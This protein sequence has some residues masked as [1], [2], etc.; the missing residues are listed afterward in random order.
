MLLEEIQCVM[1]FLAFQVILGI[2]YNDKLLLGGHKNKGSSRK[3]WQNKGFAKDRTTI[4]DGTK[5]KGISFK[6]K[7]GYDHWWASV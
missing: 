3:N 7:D 2:L 6:I 4:K 1:K 5:F